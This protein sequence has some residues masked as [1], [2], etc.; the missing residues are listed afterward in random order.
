VGLKAYQAE[1][2]A[3]LRSSPTVLQ[4]RV[5]ALT[6]NILSKISFFILEDD[7]ATLNIRLNIFKVQSLEHLSQRIHFH[8]PVA[9]YVDP[10][11]DGYINFHSEEGL[12]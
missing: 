7:I 1:A 5:V 4:F 9:G 3:I 8:Y 2:S 6:F 12:L 10:A 11:Y